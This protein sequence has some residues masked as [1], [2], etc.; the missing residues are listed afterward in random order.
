MGARWCPFMMT[1]VPPLTGPCS[2]IMPT[3]SGS[4]MYR[5]ETKLRIRLSCSV[6]CT[7]AR[8]LD[9]R[10][11][12]SDLCGGDRQ[13]STWTDWN[14][15][16]PCSWPR[17]CVHTNTGLVTLLDHD[18]VKAAG[19]TS[20]SNEKVQLTSFVTT[21]PCPWISSVLPPFD[22]PCVGQTS[23]RSICV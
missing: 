7:V 14:V 16:A 9:V 18:V 2:G 1:R 4:S 20:S 11:D 15:A 12:R 22:G 3:A 10:T 19:L 8:S 21:R 5:N 13:V 17:R 23:I 6:R